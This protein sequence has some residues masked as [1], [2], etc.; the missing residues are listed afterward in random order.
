[1]GGRVDAEHGGSWRSAAR[2][3]GTGRE[4]PHVSALTLASCATSLSAELRYAD[5]RSP[6]SDRRQNYN[7]ACLRH[8]YRSGRQRS[9]G[10][11]LVILALC[12]ALPAEHGS[13]CSDS[14]L[15]TGALSAG[16]LALKTT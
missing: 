8:R 15:E 14:E 13:G 1:M 7:A 11:H 12:S 3:F 16:M 4:A 5:L 10:A 9:T 6:G 2:A